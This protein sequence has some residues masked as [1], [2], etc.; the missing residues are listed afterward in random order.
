MVAIVAGH[1]LGLSL[2][3]LAALGQ[4]GVFGSAG[5]GRNGQQAYVNVS[6]GNLVLQS[7]DDSL[8][9]RGEDA[10][11]LR[12]YNSNGTMNDDNGDNWSM[13]VYSQQLTV[14]G[15]FGSTGS[16]IARI[17]KDGA[18]ISHARYSGTGSA[19]VYRTV[20]GDGAHDTI[21]M[22]GSDIVW[23]D[24]STGTAEMYQLS[25][26]SYRLSQITDAVGNVLTYHYDAGGK[27]ASIG[28]ATGEATYFEYAGNNLAR[29]YT[30]FLDASSVLQTQTSVRYAYD[31][32]N[33]LSMVTVDLTP[34]DNSIV[35]NNT[36]V[37]TYTYTDASS[38]RVASIAQTDGSSLVFTYDGSNR[39][40]SVTDA[41][42][43][44]TSYSYNTAGTGNWY[45]DVTDP[46]GSVTRYT[47]SSTSGRLAS[48]REPLVNGAQPTT[49]FSYDSDR[50]VSRITNARGAATEFS[51]DTAGNLLLQRDYLGNTVRRYYN[52]NNQLI[53]E[54][55]YVVPDPDGMGSAQPSE[56][57]TSRFVYD[58]T[59]KN[60]LH[61]AI[62]AEGRVTE[63]LYNAY[64]ERTSSIQ[65]KQQYNLGGL[66]ISAT[67]SEAAMQTW[68]G[69]L[70]RS[71]VIRSDMT[72]DFRGQLQSVTDWGAVSTAGVG[73]S[74]GSQ[75]VTQY[76]YDQAGLLLNT[77]SSTAGVTLYGYDGLDRLIAVTNAAGETL[78]TQYADGTRT[79]TLTRANG[80]VTIHTHD[81]AGNLVS[82]VQRNALAQSLG[83]TRHF[84][85]A[86]DR[87]R[88]T[89]DP[90]GGRTWYFY[91]TNGRRTA[92]VDADGS[93]TRFGYNVDDGLTRTTVY[94]TA[95]NT[96]T[97][98][99]GSQPN[100]TV[101][102]E[103]ILPA[104]TA[105][106]Q[107]NW[108]TYDGSDRLTKTVDSRGAVTEYVYDGASRLVK[109]I[110][111]ANLVALPTV[112]APLTA[113]VVTVASP[114]LD[115]TT[116]NFYD[117]D[118]LP[119]ATLDAEGYLTEL[120]YNSA[121]QLF[122]TTRYA[123]VTVEAN[124]P[125]GT[126]TILRPAASA[127]QDI[128]SYRLYDL[129]ARLVGEVDGE[130][131]LT[132]S[133]YDLAGNVTQTLR[134]AAKVTATVT[135]SSTLAGIRPATGASDQTTVRTYDALNRVTQETNAQGTVTSFSYDVAGNLVSTTRD[136]GNAG[137]RTLNARYDLQGR[138]TAELSAEG[139]A[140]LTGGQSQEDIDAIWAQHGLSHTYD[141][142]GRRASTTNALGQRT[143][144][145]YTADGQLSHT[146]N[147]LGEV[148]ER[149][150]NALNQLT[151]VIR[152]G[153]RLGEPVLTALNGPLAGGIANATLTT[154][155]AAIANVALDSTTSHTYTNTG[156]VASV[157]NELGGT[158]TIAYNNFGEELSRSQ[159]VGD[160]RTLV[161]SYTV[162]RRGLRTGTV[163]DASGVNAITAAV[164]DA[165]GR[166]TRSTDAR[167]NFTDYSYDR[168]GRT[169]TVVDA[170]L[171]SRSTTYDAFSRVLTQTDALGH[172]TT[173]A[174]DQAARTMTVTTNDGV[175]S[176]SVVTAYTRHGQVLS[177]ADGKGQVTSYS[178]DRN[179]NLLQTTTPI[180]TTSS[181]YDAASRLIE[182]T[183]ARGNKVAYTYDAANRMATRVVDPSGLNLATSYEW[184][185]RGRQVSTT[186][187][188]G[189]VTLTQFDL[190]GQVTKTIVDPTGLNL[191][192]VYA[193]D[194]RGKVL[195]VTSPAGRVTQYT[196]DTL[197]RRTGEVTDP[198]GL[199]ILRS[200]AYDKNGNVASAT[201]ANGNVTRY[202][203]DKE[204]RLVYTVDALGNLQ[205]NT[206]DAQGRVSKT[207]AYAKPISLTAPSALPAMPSVSDISGR[208][209][210]IVS[211]GDV[212]EHRI[213]DH[214]DR[215]QATVD[216]TGAVVKYTYDANGQVTERVAYANRINLGSWT[217]GTNPAVTP[218][219]SRDERERVVYDALGRAVYT[220]NGTGSVTAMAYDGNGNLVQSRRYATPVPLA[221]AATKVALDAAV[222]LITNNAKDEVTRIVHDAANRAT[223]S[224]DATG[225]VTVRTY[226]GNGNVVQ[227]V[228]YANRI[229]TATPVTRQALD[230]AV[231]GAADAAR[232][233]VLRTVFDAGN[234]A[235]HTIDGQGAVTAQVYDADGNV[236][237]R[238][239]WATAVSTATA[240]T[241]TALETAVAGIADA[242]RDQTVR[243]V[244]DA[245][246]RMT[247]SVDGV[248]AV[249]QLAYDK[250][251]N[252]VGETRYA[253]A[254]PTGAAADATVA[255]STR[256]RVTGWAYD[257]ANR[258]VF[259]IDALNGVT[260]QFYDGIGHIVKRTAYANALTS[261]P[262]LGLAASEGNVRTAISVSAASDRSTRF[263]YDAAGRQVIAVDALGGITE[264]RYD[265]G[266]RVSQSV[267]YAAMANPAGAMPTLVEV[268]ALANAALDRVHTRAYDAAGRL[269]YT[270][271]PLGSVVRT[272]YD[273]AGRVTAT[274]A[275]GLAVSSGTPPVAGAIAAAVTPNAAEDRI[276]QYAWNAAG[277]LTAS[278][279]PLGSTES[280]THDAL[281]NKLSFTNKKGSVW[282]YE[283]DTAGRLLA[284]HSPQ[285]ALT[286]V[287]V[288]GSGKL[289]ASASAQA[290]IV[291]RLAY[292]ALGNLLQRTE[293]A[294]RAGEERITQYQYD[295]L[296]RQVRTIYPPVAVYNAAADSLT[297]NGA[298]G[299]AARTETALTALESWTYYDTLGDAVASRDVANGISQKAYDKLGRLAYDVDA[300]GYVTGYTRNTFGDTLVQTR[301][302]TAT[303]LASVNLTTAAQAVTKA[304]V[305]A[306]VLAVGFDRAKDR[307]LTTTWDRLGRAT[308]VR[309][310]AGFT[311]DSSAA[312]GSQTSTTTSST[313]QTVYNAFGN[314]VQVKRL[315][316]A[317]TS[318]WVSTF[319]YFD[320]AGRET[321]TVD[322]LRY[323]TTRSFDA[324]G[325]QLSLT[326]YATALTGTPTTAGYGSAP[327]TSLN[328]RVTEYTWDRANRKTAE[329]RRDV[330][331][332]AGS[333]GT[334][335]RG[336]LTTSYGYDAVGN[337]TQ[338]TDALGSTTWTYFDALGRITAIAAPPVTD[339]GVQRTPLTEF[340]RDAYG[341]VIVKTDYALGTTS[342]GATSYTAPT[343]SADDRHNLA[344]YDSH[345]HA[346]QTMDALDH[347][348]H[349]SWDKKGNLAKSWQS[350]QGSDGQ[351]RTAFEVYQYDK[352]GQMTN[353]ITPAS[354]SVL[355][356]GAINTVSQS[357]AGVV[358]IATQYNAFG[359]VVA[360][361]TAGGTLQEY[362]D[363]D[364]A[365]RLWRTN[366]GD[367]V[368]RVTLYDALG[369]ATADIR[370]TG[371]TNLKA[372][373]DAA[374]AH[375][376]TATRR[377]DVH[378]DAMGRVTQQFLAARQELQG[379]VTVHQM[380]AGVDIVERQVYTHFNNEDGPVWTGQNRVTVNWSSLAGLGSGDVRVQLEYRTRVVHHPSYV[381]E[382]SNTV[383]PA[384]DEYGTPR[385]VVRFFDA[386]TAQTSA[387]VEWQDVYDPAL[388]I[389]GGLNSVTRVIVH[390]KDVNGVWREVINHA[391]GSATN[392]IDVAAPPDPDTLITLKLK[393]A[394]SPTWGAPV[395]MTAFGDKFRYDARSLAAGNYDY[396]VE[397]TPVGGTARTV[398]TGTMTLSAPALSAMAP[399]MVFGATGVLPSVLSW[400]V[401]SAG[402]NQVF[403][404]RPAGS[405]GAWTSVTPTLYDEAGRLGVNMTGL[406]SGNYQFELL[407]FN[408]G[409]GTPSAH[410]TGNITY[411]APSGPV[412]V[413]QV[414]HPR[415]VNFA[416][417]DLTT[418]TGAAGDPLVYNA[419][420]Q[421]TFANE[422]DFSANLVNFARVR[423]IGSSTWINATVMTV[424]G[425]GE[426]GL[427]IAGTKQVV[428]LSGLGLGSGNYELEVLRHSSGGS[429]LARGT[430]TFSLT[431]S[432]TAH[433]T[434][435]QVWE[436]TYAPVIVSYQ[437]VY[438]TRTGV[439]YTTEYYWVPNPTVYL[440]TNE[441]GQ[442]IYGPAPQ[443]VN[444]TGQYDEN[445]SPIYG[446]GYRQP[447]QQAHYYNYQVQVGTTPVYQRDENGNIVYTIS[448][449]G[450]QNR[451]AW[452][453]AG[454]P[455]P[456]TNV[457]T[458]TP[459]YTAAYTIPA[460]V[461]GFSVSL[462]TPASSAALSN[463][464][465][466]LGTT[467]GVNGG[468]R[469]VRPLVTQKTDRWGN[470]TEITDPRAA[471]WKTTYTYN[472]NNQLVKE[473]KP[474]AN[475]QGA[476]ETT[477]YYDQLGRQVAVKDALGRINGQAWDSNGRLVQES[478]ADGGVITHSYN[479]FGDKTHTLD[480]MNHGTLYTYDKLG[481]LLSMTQG[482][483]QIGIYAV[484]G[485][486]QAYRASTGSIVQSYTYDELGRRKSET[487]GAGGV[488]TYQ[489]DLRGNIVAT[490]RLGI[491]SRA[492]YNAQDRRTAETDPNEQ[493]SQWVMNYFG[494]VTTMVNGAG[495][496]S[497]EYNAAGLLTLLTSTRNQHIS[498][499]Y[500]GAGQLTQIT[501]SALNQVTS[502]QYDMAGNKVREQTTQSGITYQDNH[503]A[504]DALGRLRD[505]ADGR[506]HITIDYDK[507]GN[508]TLI[509]T[510][511]NTVTSYGDASHGSARYFQ[512]D[513]M[514]RQ[515][516]VDGVDA[517]GNIGQ[518]GHLITY[519]LNGNRT[520]DTSWGNRVSST[521]TPPEILYY[522]TENEAVYSEETTTY[523][524]SEGFA[525]TVYRYD[526]LNRLTSAETDGIQLDARLYDGAGRVIKSGPGHTLPQAYVDKLNEGVPLEERIG[527]ETKINTYNA[528][529]RLVH[530]K[531][532]NTD[533]SARSDTVYT[534]ID[535]AGNITGY[536]VVNQEGE[537]TANHYTNTY[538]IQL[539]RLAG[540]QQ[541]VISGTST[542]FQPG[543]TTQ[544]FD[545]NGHLIG[546]DDSTMNA[547]D[548]SFIND[549]NGQALLVNQNG[550]V[551]RQLI[552]NG[553]VLGRF[554]VGVDQ[555]NP[556]DNRSNPNFTNIVD[557]EFGYQG[558]TASYP[559][560]AP[561]AYT[562]RTGDTLKSI[563]QSAYG[564]SSL[565]Y[566]IAQANGMSS[567][568]DLRAGQTINIPNQVTGASN[569][570][571][572][573]Q[574][575]DPSR[576][577]GDKTPNLPSPPAPSGGGGCGGIGKLLMAIVA[578]VATIYT[579]GALSGVTTGFGATMTAGVGV[580]S[581]GAITTGVGASLTFAGT[582]AVA[583]G[584]GSIASQVVGIAT[585][586]Q[587]EFSW[588]GV[589]LAAI[590]GGISAGV[591]SM[592]PS[593]GSAVTNAIVR[594]AVGNAL[595]QGVAVAT[596]LQDRFSWKS[597]AASAVGAGV[598]AAV[599]GAI[600]SSLGSS[601]G[602]QFA[603]RAIS[604]FA[605]G[606]T[607]AALSGGR[608]SATQ[609]AI[610]AFG[611]ALGESIAGGMSNP[612]EQ[613]VALATI[614]T[615]GEGAYSA[616][617]YI[618]QM[619][620]QSDSFRRYTPRDNTTLVTRS[621]G[622]NQIDLSG[623]T[624]DMDEATSAN[625]NSRL[626]L[627]GETVE[628]S[629]VIAGG[630][631]FS[632]GRGTGLRSADAPL[633]IEQLRRSEIKQMNGSAT[634]A[635]ASGASVA[636]KIGQGVVGGLELLLGGAYNSVLSIGGGAASLLYSA[637]S[638][639][640]AVGVQE[641]IKERIGYEMQSSGALA[642][643][644][645]LQPLGNWVQDN[646]FTPAR[647]TS[648]NAIGDGATTF[649]SVGIQAGLEIVGVAYGG[650]VLQNT[651]NAGSSASAVARIDSKPEWLARI[652]RG[653]AF[654]AERRDAYQFSEVYVNNPNGTGHYRLDSYS[655]NSGEI[656]SRKFTQ[657]SEITDKTA[658]AYIAEIGAKYPVGA[659]LSNVPT[660]VENGLVGQT[661]KGRYIL[662]VP[663][664]RKPIPIAYIEKADRAG[665]LIR[666]VKGK[667]Y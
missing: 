113:S 361:G 522:G 365:G 515:T 392:V 424:G 534:G 220:V 465:T 93:L 582:M 41:L 472:A 292:D 662:E 656:V 437:P 160:G 420:I 158:T 94:A 7:H 19:A 230:A 667:V 614:E 413:P 395:A 51:Y 606:M 422:A 651:L 514:N 148:E 167:S 17:A 388:G 57:L 157:T 65:Y 451:Q 417:T 622:G 296:G 154:A 254:L 412:Y 543:T 374:V 181:A 257:K 126:L 118:G 480:A 354:T 263:A 663:V 454:Q 312:A 357:A 309:E 477:L 70:D 179:G 305:E 88:M 613:E 273:A 141:A 23:T 433:N 293:A 360:R 387:T 142:A 40:S 341:N 153:T 277:Q 562:T 539:E 462:N 228:A 66:A 165:F 619:D 108:R 405:T 394:G 630:P 21:R 571:T 73:I 579:V 468:D 407:Q 8:V 516:V 300:M 665:V 271:D 255:T 349:M 204:N 331:Y 112:D 616:Q 87:L 585:G 620:L 280:F 519:D 56:P 633:T 58:S 242:A 442:P 132:E 505:V 503:L 304:G 352:L 469:N 612:G 624:P 96:S 549:V 12:T 155:L 225:A 517:V 314:A 200:Y 639:G 632:L 615:Q 408:E 363:Y 323:L 640:A 332:S 289:V 164:Y 498:Y 285:V 184:D 555:V 10:V 660:N 576:I 414:G 197:G 287:S 187:A 272:V 589:A 344:R 3:S 209:A 320:Q 252:V 334:S 566:V 227:R 432:G 299:L 171:A 512:Y 453:A 471:Y 15:A 564:D 291:T 440:G 37:T 111:Y 342:A 123:T 322:A 279:D 608:V 404:Y 491:T 59:G 325:N 53:S 71:G 401:P 201:D 483:G 234:R 250:Q 248:G 443:P 369:N 497:Y 376:S 128:I 652:E 247:R 182:T 509:T 195:S 593:T 578:I 501:D 245:A 540:Y 114:T 590:G 542:K 359:E 72:Y 362:F 643:G 311:Y 403:N 241:K 617:D 657:L 530:Q 556:R 425:I 367:G 116:R 43:R 537:N 149:R 145:F 188:N 62:S 177:V 377:V 168:L 379:G 421:W 602:G 2:T 340:R 229:S 34:V 256:D 107:S 133:V 214:V 382:N 26:G 654:N 449:Y 638:V 80:L 79:T 301:Y 418:G 546:V 489:I 513:A 14:S 478:H 587:E 91:D 460:V 416:R 235:T 567:D 385:S 531:V 35:D 121:G 595:T 532:L 239:A 366:S 137:A 444:W 637:D 336:H 69:G 397:V 428:Y 371:A 600:G 493:A 400:P 645:A 328:D 511:V 351:V 445:G 528:N 577:E 176:I 523:Q 115:R 119:L 653:S 218:D 487:D 474:A 295:A 286:T 554:G 166:V 310:T 568:S 521:T 448:G 224:V 459:S 666:D 278:T 368:D 68:A 196:Y 399:A 270:V 236:V 67:P 152:Y 243:R 276:Q 353:S 415:I 642:I 347:S 482:A 381:D 485:S 458:T 494:Q 232:D 599:S 81:L 535:A 426:D 193:W 500:D 536:Q 240:A 237:R 163:A 396:L 266:G 222:A 210:A 573:F 130:G 410:A 607:T 146:V 85:D 618:N 151:S 488:T 117:S 423:A 434:T 479:V 140:L 610:D 226:D 625:L 338:T 213:Y 253:T 506:A 383:V 162:D 219:E 450:W 31:T 199:N 169:V 559:N 398:G 499:T 268:Q 95:V 189:I 6:N 208:I 211:A 156:R 46:T 641:A 275:Y 655:P 635:S 575:Y 441:S 284:E 259:T 316:N 319:H 25:G 104:T 547:N 109:T 389:D 50:N 628:E 343:S 281:G 125:T 502:Y 561:G 345:G 215:M 435:I 375:A 436:P 330:E 538:S 212:V 552:V 533:G 159:A 290:S 5:A 74:N 298:S 4:Q 553:E 48:V 623:F 246:G 339:G 185:A 260:E 527:A 321:A 180:T 282:T 518:Q 646:V 223:H 475:A 647:I 143:L 409:S 38:R 350:V 524:R 326:E 548:K 194:G 333:N 39:V 84:Y 473:T 391:A 54:S 313:T 544:S 267:A 658:T 308:E 597:V 172:A 203:Y 206:Y 370:S 466:G 596:G 55:S 102:L 490:T 105:D 92:Q 78:T 430:A 97:L 135:T 233:S 327:A 373:A 186:D 76:V 261:V 447:Y 205:A 609:V 545:A 629:W 60:L 134:Y 598:G 251:G 355:Q 378:Y 492:A 594:S 438:E 106:D 170:M 457:S 18:V 32:A 33:R 644:Q 634:A 496:H 150:Y 329:T 75:S 258:Q 541:K 439:Y 183:D 307:S 42:G 36:Y 297:V 661:L 11:A 463:G 504:Y 581:A 603:T 192:T 103:S 507:V 198:A 601:A 611:N 604:G 386:S 659:K 249:T 83:E 560:A 306:V 648:E 9:R 174:Y 178:Y 139:A 120:T 649:L 303:S 627:S 605:A 52:A 207:V 100:L 20:E 24:G 461:G 315:Q 636:E 583:A 45:T 335:T 127:T 13:G 495:T 173:Y 510:H 216:G 574:P 584:V 191:Q 337:L 529:G 324:L 565:W 419:G 393:V 244:F 390:K 144:Y 30:T 129:K 558:I 580:M 455:D 238:T 147:A 380:Q 346:V 124:R 1:S 22:V 563:A 358:N 621:E 16:T 525:S 550:N 44:V 101:T 202:A 318:A 302:G 86:A 626:G 317:A 456:A 520:S 592:L 221:T 486:G 588:K 131:Y 372:M 664:Q 190:K 138:L 526:A 508:R 569:N 110:Q 476:P 265:A 217:P 356:G 89:E 47:F 429:V 551:M 470:V 29:V 464:L 136:V 99:N 572:T 446:Y 98:M 570:A 411:T 63:Y 122:K 274:T 61:F 77:I 161:E 427:L 481:Q 431:V 650:K 283:Y 452:V 484:N 231:L 364:N 591:G 28:A 384:Y 631:S 288:D 269:V 262:A 557:W 348:V 467:T 294:G 586:V 175:N 90:A 27:L 406:G 402:V 264:T 82:V 49:Q 64:G